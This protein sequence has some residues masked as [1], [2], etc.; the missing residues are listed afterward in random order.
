MGGAAGGGHDRD[1]ATE[2]PEAG[3]RVQLHHQQEAPRLE[4]VHGVLDG[5]GDRC[6]DRRGT[7]TV[8]LPGSAKLTGD[9]EGG[10]KLRQ[11]ADVALEHYDV[12]VAV[13]TGW[14]TIAPEKAAHLAR[15][16]RGFVLQGNTEALIGTKSQST[17]GPTNHAVWVNEV[18][19]G[20][21]DKPDKALVYDPAADGRVRNGITFADG[22]RWWPWERVLAF[23]AALRPNGDDGKKLGPGKF[24]AGFVP[25]RPATPA[26]RAEPGRS[27][28]RRARWTVGHVPGRR[29][30]D[31]AV[32]GPGPRQRG[33]GPP[34]E[35]PRTTRSTAEGRHRRPDPGWHALRRVPGHHERGQ[36]TGFEVRHL[37]WQP[38]RH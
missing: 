5:D 19:G 2:I 13:R 16:G 26:A 38:T 36:A 34:G 33:E 32:P 22:P 12:R 14:N 8:G 6:R 21:D 4:V 1:A 23:A 3:T 29:Q 28:G 15:S 10:L 37:V 25:R 31:E 20:T 17:L 9:T 24:Y 18:K 30:A 27:H 35:R 7:A 11:V